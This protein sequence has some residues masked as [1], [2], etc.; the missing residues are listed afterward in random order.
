LISEV[1]FSA[2]FACRTWNSVS[3][4]VPDPPP[5]L[6]DGEPGVPTGWTELDARPS[7]S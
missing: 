3:C 1:T 5:Q 6:L 4:Y 7:I 2:S